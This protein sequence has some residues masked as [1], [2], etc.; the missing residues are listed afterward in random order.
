MNGQH[1]GDRYVELSV[2]SYQDY[3]KFN[4]PS[5]GG[6]TVKLAKFVGAE[7]QD[8]SLVMRG[9]PYRVNSEDI[10]NFFSGYGSLTLDDIIIEEFNGKRS[11]SALVI[12]ENIDVA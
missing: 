8:R 3:S 6:N 9:L 12:F 5:S 10:L 7:N 2:I 11:G 1:V 4:G